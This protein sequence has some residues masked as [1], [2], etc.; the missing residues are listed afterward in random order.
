MPRHQ[1]ARAHGASFSVL[2]SSKVN[3][4][5]ND[6]YGNAQPSVNNFR[7]K[8]GWRSHGVRHAENGPHQHAPPGE[9]PVCFAPMVFYDDTLAGDAASHNGGNNNQKEIPPRTGLD[10][11]YFAVGKRVQKADAVNRQTQDS[12]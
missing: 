11:H 2:K 1:H 3:E 7:E 4:I 5:R 9:K 12:P 8:S 10:I 6:L